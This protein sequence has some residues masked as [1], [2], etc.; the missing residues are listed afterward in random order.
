MKK[1]II[2]Y[3]LG[4]GYKNKK[5]LFDATFDIIG[6]SD[7]NVSKYKGMQGFIVPHDIMKHDFTYVVIGCRFYAEVINYLVENCD[8]PVEKIRTDYQLLPSRDYFSATLAEDMRVAFLLHAMGI[9]P[10]NI[11]YLELGTN[12]PVA[13]NNTYYFYRCGAHG[14]LV[15]ANPKWSRLIR[16]VRPRDVFL[17][18]AVGLCAN[19]STALLYETCADEGS[20]LR[21][22]L[23]DKGINTKNHEVLRTHNVQTITVQQIL[24]GLNVMPEL[25]SVDIEGMD[26]DVLC[27]IDY[28][29]FRPLIIIAETFAM[30]M[31]EQQ[32]DNI[33][34]LLTKNGYHMSSLSSWSNGIFVREDKFMETEKSI[35]WLGQDIDHNRRE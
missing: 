24:A 15:E 8:V 21:I 6:F 26:Y 19:G 22:D 3:G 33:E 31:T 9:Q 2:I 17:N 20:T 12:D 18:R 25:L 32:G 28:S 23:Y 7:T 4:V 30:N 16:L 13:H 1:K 10:G 27:T 34:K 5:Q 14:T 29:L 35:A 11:T